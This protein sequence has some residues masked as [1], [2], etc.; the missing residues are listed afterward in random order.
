MEEILLGV[1]YGSS[2]TGLAFGR[3]GLVSPLHVI[4]SKDLNFVKAE[5]AKVSLGNKVSK[6]IMGLPLDVDG[7]DTTQSK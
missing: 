5:I 6:V 3:E 7:K 4:D 2:H 1:D